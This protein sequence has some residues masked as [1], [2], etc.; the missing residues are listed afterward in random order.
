MDS[1]FAIGWEDDMLPHGLNH[2]Q[3]RI[4]EEDGCICGR[5]KT[6]KYHD[7]YVEKD[8]AMKKVLDFR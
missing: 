5:Y 4:E 2:S 8:K 7:D 3:K 1:V 6:Q